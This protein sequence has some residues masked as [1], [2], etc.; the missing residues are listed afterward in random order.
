MQDRVSLQRDACS[1]SLQSA[2]KG[3]ILSESE[4]KN[5]LFVSEEN[6]AFSSFPMLFVISRL[7]PNGDMGIYLLFRYEMHLSEQ[8]TNI[9]VS[10]LSVFGVMRCI[11]SY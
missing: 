1:F 6:A 10:F 11:S 5:K 3:I 9:V 2:S 8:V 7:S 4:K